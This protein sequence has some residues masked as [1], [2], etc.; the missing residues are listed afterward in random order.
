MHLSIYLSIYLS[1]N[2]PINQSINQSIDHN[3]SIDLSYYLPIL[4]YPILS[5][6]ILSYPILSIYI[7][8]LN[9]HQAYGDFSHGAHRS[10]PATGSS[11]AP[12]DHCHLVGCLQLGGRCAPCEGL[13]Y[14]PCGLAGLARET[15]I[16][17]A[18]SLRM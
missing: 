11:I 10:I 6:P 9:N 15:G 16:G 18:W 4:S 12:R 17:G 2:Q 5:Y 14:P 3:R 13:C 7:Y 1:I 8:V